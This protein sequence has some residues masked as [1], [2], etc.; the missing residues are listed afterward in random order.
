MPVATASAVSRIDP[1]RSSVFSAEEAVGLNAARSD[2]YRV[3]RI[4][5]CSSASAMSL[6]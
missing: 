2:R 4:D 3:V 5:A 6:G 1:S